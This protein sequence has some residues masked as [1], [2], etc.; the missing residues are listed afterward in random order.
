MTASVFHEDWFCQ[1]SCAALAHLART[2]AL[3]DGDIVEIGSWEGRSTI[4]LAEAAAPAT[5]HAVDHWQ[6]SPRE[7]SADLA[8]ERDVFAT[9]QANTAHL[10]NIEVHR[11]GWREYFAAHTDPLRF[12]FI[13]AEHT[14]R[15]VFDTIKTVL[16]LMV[17]N[18]IICGDDV[19]HRPVRQA[20]L[21][22]FPDAQTVATLW[23]HRCP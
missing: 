23:W 10:T 12:V 19:H 15:E 14:Y 9:F 11:Q 18:G 8:A 5:V 13:D 22:W 4:A 1:E 17:R 7:I 2:V 20:A 21:D 6:G 3:L 16:P